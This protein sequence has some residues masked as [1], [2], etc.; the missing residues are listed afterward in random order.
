[1]YVPKSALC[2]HSTWQT[3]LWGSLVT[4]RVFFAHAP[5]L[6]LCFF[7]SV[8]RIL[9]VHRYILELKAK[10]NIVPTLD[11]FKVLRVLGEGGFGQVCICLYLYIYTYTYTCIARLI[12]W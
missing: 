5:V 4:F 7:V 9:S 1:M 8:K 2:T 10:E 6:G 3:P 12:D 11:D